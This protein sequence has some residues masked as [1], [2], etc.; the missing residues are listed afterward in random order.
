MAYKTVRVEKSDQITTLTLNRPEAKNAMNPQMHFDMCAALDEV[1]RDEDCRAVVITGS[2]DSFCA[3]MDL[4]EYFFETENKPA[5]RAAARKA[6]FEWMF[7]KLRFLPKPTIAAVNGWCFGGA[8]AWLCVCDFAVASE[9]ATFGLS[10]VN[11]GIIPAGGVTKLVSTLLSPRDAR[12]LVMTGKT[13]DGR[14][15]ECM[16]LVNSTVPPEK[17]MEAARELADNLKQKHPA[18]LACAKEVLRVDPGLT[19]EDALA[20]ETAKWNE[21]DALGKKTWHKGVKQFKEQKSYRPGLEAYKWK[22]D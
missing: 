21:L 16:R 22:E 1:E 18:V 10:E 5:E 11:W 20:W 9:K 8:F 17:L 14:E 2:G 15:A 6:A 3:G 4:K 19:L 12:Y 7:R 13:I